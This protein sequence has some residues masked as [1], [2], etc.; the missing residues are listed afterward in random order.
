MNLNFRTLHRKS[1]PIIFIPLFLTALTGI[2]FRLGRTWFGIPDDVA[3]WFL[4]IHQGEFLGQMLVPIYVLLMGMGLLGMIITGLTMLRRKNNPSAKPK[5]D[6]RWFHRA[7]APIAFLPLIVS[8][9]TGIGYR[10]GKAWFGLPTEQAA[11]LL[12]IHQGS[13]LGNFWRVFYVLLVGAGLVTLLI[14][15]MQ[16][17]GIFRQRRTQT[18]DNPK[19]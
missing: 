14:T 18:A 11:L 17:T 9:T 8:A 2:A 15:G 4:V 3:E 13:Y 1:A 6:V 16:M 19:E 10:V 7:L 5:R 12:R